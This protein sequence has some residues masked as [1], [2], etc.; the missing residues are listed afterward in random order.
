MVDTGKVA[1]N[2]SV[3]IKVHLAEAASLFTTTAHCLPAYACLLQRPHHT[4]HHL[5]PHLT[6]SMPHHYSRQPPP[7]LGGI[8]ATQ[9]AE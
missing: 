7:H 8:M 6:T 1:Y 4:S 3:G 2:V 9:Q 5:L